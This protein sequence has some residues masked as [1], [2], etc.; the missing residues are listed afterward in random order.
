MGLHCRTQHA[1][2]AKK[3]KKKNPTLAHPIKQLSPPM[4]YPSANNLEKVECQH[5]DLWGAVGG[6]MEL[7]QPMR[8]ATGSSKSASQLYPT[9]VGVVPVGTNWAAVHLGRSRG[10]CWGQYRPGIYGCLQYFWH[11]APTLCKLV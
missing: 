2:R 3:K 9:V 10:L 7:L 5:G 8:L 1:H 11:P 4:L 6:G